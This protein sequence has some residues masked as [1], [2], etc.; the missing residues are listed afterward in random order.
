MRKNKEA[1]LQ[2]QQRLIFT[3]NDIWKHLPK[4]R[5]DQCRDLLSQ[6]LQKVIRSGSAKE[7]NNEP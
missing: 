4:E 5:Q 2:V 7:K 1:F 3:R 6:L